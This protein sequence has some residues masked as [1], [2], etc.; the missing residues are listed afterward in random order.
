MHRSFSDPEGKTAQKSRRCLTDN[1]AFTLIELLIVIAIISILAGML[2][3]AL[4]NA[5]DAAKKTICLSNQKQIGLGTMMYAGDYNNLVPTYGVSDGD[6][7]DNF[8]GLLDPYVSGKQRNPYYCNLWLCPNDPSTDGAWWGGVSYGINYGL[9]TLCPGYIASGPP[10]AYCARLDKLGAP[11]ATLY[12]AEHGKLEEM[13]TN[14]SNQ[15]Y[16]LVG[17][18][19]CYGWGALGDYH[20]SIANGMTNV[21]FADNHAES[22]FNSWLARSEADI[23]NREPWYVYYGPEYGS[24]AGCWCSA[25][26]RSP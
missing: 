26:V 17:P 23:G 25:V 9:Y 16:P 21:L 1:M 22:R 3:P 8:V 11:S 4:K 5:K 6:M 15:Q 12:I 7:W 20:G 2:L 18:G 10:A 24:T 14:W 19:N 13:G